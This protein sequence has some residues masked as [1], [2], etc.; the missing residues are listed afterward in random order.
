MVIDVIAYILGFDIAVL[1]FSLFRELLSTG[2]I[3]DRIFGIPT[4]FPCLVF[5][6][7]GFI[8]LGLFSAL[9]RK[10]LFLIGRNK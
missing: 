2:A 6:F 7:G 9:Y 1:I 10:I 3:G 8:L 4:T 5:P